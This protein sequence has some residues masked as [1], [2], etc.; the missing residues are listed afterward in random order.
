MQYTKAPNVRH[1]LQFSL[2]LAQNVRKKRSFKLYKDTTLS[3]V[4]NKVKLTMLR[5]WSVKQLP[6]SAFPRS[7]TWTHCESK[8]NISEKFVLATARYG[9]LKYAGSLAL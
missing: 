8:V 5:L 9:Y 4:Y 2:S 1:K 6:G 3:L 7:P